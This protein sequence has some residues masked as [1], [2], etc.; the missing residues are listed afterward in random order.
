M[1]SASILG[2][3][4]KS[5]G[6][7]DERIVRI[8]VISV[9][10][11]QALSEARMF[12]HMCFKGGNSLR[13]IFARR[14]SR[15]SMDLD[16]VDAS[17]EQISDT[18]LKADDYYLKLLEHIDQR[19][20]YD[21]HWR[22]VPLSELELAVDTVRFDIHYFVH[23]DK[24]DE[25]WQNRADNVLAFECSFRRPVLFSKEIREL[26]TES[27]F[28]HLEFAPAPIPVLRLEEAIAEKI[29]AAFQRD[30]ARDIFDLYQ[31]G[32]LIFDPQLVRPA[33]VLKCWQDRGLYNGA[34]NFDPAEFMAK[35]VPANY[36]WETL[37]D[38]VAP[39]AWVEPAELLSKV[40]DRYAFLLEITDTE[41][42][43]CRDRWQKR[44]DIHDALWFELQISTAI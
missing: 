2:R 21:I 12:N 33:A 14:P 7:E 43:L 20:I 30:N 9:Y 19:T 23:D 10:L 41:N 44:Q 38:Q 32:Q 39:H 31:Y 5:A 34:T 17:Y 15:F 26:R 8:D 25:G 24:P 36:A 3:I 29:R 18:G 22:V 4:I 40:R 1:I 6:V 27:W 28:K 13:K 37:K 35:L 42:E 11:L 16:F